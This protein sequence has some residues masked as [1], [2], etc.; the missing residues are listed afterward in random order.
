M[1]LKIMH[2][3]IF[4]GFKTCYY[5][6]IPGS[7]GLIALYCGTMAPTGFVERYQCRQGKGA[8]PYGMVKRFTVVTSGSSSFDLGGV[9]N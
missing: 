4:N 6:R 5:I 9:H 2:T 1:A 7:T 3:S 8:L